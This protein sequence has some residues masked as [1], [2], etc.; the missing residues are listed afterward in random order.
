M[1]FVTEMDTAIKSG[2]AGFKK[3]I[4]D[5]MQTESNYLEQPFWLPQGLQM[6]VLNYLIQQHQE[7]KGDSAA[8]E[9]LIDLTEYIDFII[10][11]TQN[12][13]NG[14]P[15][16]QAIAL[17]KTR[18]ALHLLGKNTFAVDGHDQ[19][20]KT[21]ISLTLSMRNKHLLRKVLQ[22]KPNIYETTLVTKERIPYQ[23]LHEAILADF[24]F[25]VKLLAEAGAQLDNPVG[26]YMDTPL[27][28][29]VRWGKIRALEMLLEFPVAQLKLDAESMERYEDKMHGDNAIES[30]CRLLEKRTNS[31]S[32]ING[33]AMLLCC[34]AE[35]PRRMEMCQLLANKQAELLKAISNYLEHRPHLV[36]PFVERCHVSGSPLHEMM[37]VNHSWKNGLFY[38]LG[39]PNKTAVT[40]ESWVSSKYKDELPSKAAT[41]YTGQESPLKLYAE[42]VR[43]YEEA[44]KNQRITFPW[45][46]M[47][48]RISAGQC[49]WGTVCEYAEL[50]PDSRTGIII[51]DMIKV[52]PQKAMS[53]EL[54]STEK[55]SLV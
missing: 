32:L 54:D 1:E 2:L 14:M 45:S 15:L 53:D 38:L 30:L 43:R 44:Y 42:F 37:Y 34:G 47:R 33:I 35:L 4:L 26:I 48:W 12:K 23:P 18:L 11:N 9:L 21:L 49:S 8:E 20:G 16:H 24:P 41:T 17:K 50:Y 22:Q 40:V 25:A 5:K 31:K 27:L 46:T 19:D 36:D 10:E 51:K 3:F 29:A 13:D 7:K 55:P 52:M 28:L 6:T 39:W